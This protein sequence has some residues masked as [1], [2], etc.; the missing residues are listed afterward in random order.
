MPRSLSLLVLLILS[1]ITVLSKQFLKCGFLLFLLRFLCFSL[2]HQN[3]RTVRVHSEYLS[4]VQCRCRIHV[5]ICGC[6]CLSKS[7][8]NVVANAHTIIDIVEVRWQFG[9][10]DLILL[11]Y[12][13]LQH[14]WK[15]HLVACSWLLQFEL[16]GQ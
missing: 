15:H 14:P 6:L 7:S 12:L 5:A 11:L 2:L 13:L 10:N 9:S 1:G 3:L 16:K 8:F 4:V